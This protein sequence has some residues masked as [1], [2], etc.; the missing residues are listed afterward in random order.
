MKIQVILIFF[1][2]LCISTFYS[3]AQEGK[4]LFILSGQSNMVGLLPEESFTPMLERE[5]GKENVI[6][7]KQAMGTQ[8]IRRWY[9]NWEPL[10]GDEPKADPVLYDTLM[11]KV[12]AAISKKKIRKK[13][14]IASVTFI[15]MQG[16][17]DAREKLGD[18]YE[19]SLTGLYKQLSRDLKRK[20]INFI[21][22]RLS[23]FDMQNEKYPH[24]TMIREIQVNVGESNPRFAWIN[25]DDL[26]D[27]FDRN[28]NPINND[29]HMSGEGYITLGARFAEKAIQLITNVKK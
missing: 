6:I 15:W 20:D 2:I 26:N 17:R 18:V 1:L 7:A 14:K 28:N 13:N 9:K 23:D 25:T 3:V 11:K 29:L 16:E 27:G 22:G 12:Y 24:W 8:P 5:F 21:I 4:H 19:R 10:V